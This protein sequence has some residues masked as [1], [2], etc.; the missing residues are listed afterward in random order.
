MP[1]NTIEEI[2][3][4]KNDNI[5]ETYVKE[6]C[7]ECAN[8]RNTKDLCNIVITIEK[9]ARCINYEK[10]MKNQC[11]TCNENLNCNI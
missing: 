1:M 7:S 9:K 2:I 10:C 3:N 6:I 8:R 4:K 11:K 5:Y